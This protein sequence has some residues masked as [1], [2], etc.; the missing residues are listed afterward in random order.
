MLFAEQY[1]RLLLVAHA[2]LGAAVVAASTHLVVWMRGYPRGSFQRI[3]AVRRFAV[4]SAGLFTLTLLGGN[5]IYP[6]YKVH[7]RTGYL[8][9]PDVV[10]SD[11]QSRIETQAQTRARYAAGSAPEIGDRAA[12]ED[13]VAIAGLPRQAARIARWFDVKEHWVALG[14][15]LSIGCAL[16]LRTWN[17]RR[18]GPA[19]ASLIFLMALGAAATAW[20]GAIV[21]IVV[22]S[23]RAVGGPG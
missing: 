20:L 6:V 2:I 17:P 14:A 7:V 1:A 10:A 9:R 13:R 4:I 18:H 12:I 15:A 21:G 22:S 23:Y 11:Y 3:R 16:A 8:E 19:I 5:L